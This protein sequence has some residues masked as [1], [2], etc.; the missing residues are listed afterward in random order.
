MKTTSTSKRLVS[1]LLAVIMVLSMMTVGMVTSFAAQTDIAQTGATTYYLKGTFNNWGTNNPFDDGVTTLTIGAGTYTFKI[2]GSGDDSGWYSNSG[3]INDTTGT[4]AWDFSNDSNTCKLVATGGTYTFKL[5]TT[6]TGKT[7]IVEHS[8]S[9]GGDTTA[10]VF[11]SGENIYLYPDS[12]IWGAAGAQFGAHFYRTADNETRDIMFQSCND[13]GYY[14]VTVPAGDWDKLSLVR[15]NPATNGVFDWSKKWNELSDLS[16]VQNKNCFVIKSWEGGQGY[17]EWGSHPCSGTGTVDPTEEPTVKPTD[18][19]S[20]DPTT[21]E[22]FYFFDNS[23][24]QFM[25]DYNASLYATFDNGKKLQMKQRVDTLTGNNL[26]SVAVPDNSTKVSVKRVSKLDGATWGTWNNIPLS[27]KTTGFYKAVNGDGS[28]ENDETKFSPSS[29]DDITNFWYGAWVDTKGE[30]KAHDAVRWWKDGSNQYHIFLPSHTPSTFRLYSSFKSITLN[31]KTATNGN[32]IELSNIAS[33]TKLSGDYVPMGKTSS[34]SLY[35]TFHK[36]S[37]VSTLFL[38][39]DD[40]FYTSTIIKPDDKDKNKVTNYKDNLET[41]GSIYLYSKKGALVNNGDGETKLKK[42][43]GRGNSSFEA[44]MKLYGKYAYNFNLEKNVSLIDGATKTKK[45]CLLANNV[46]HAMLRNT[47]AYSIAAEVGL[48]YSPKTRHVDVFNVGEYIGAYTIIEKVEYG[49]KSLMSGLNSLDDC[50]KKMY[51]KFDP[52]GDY[53]DA[54]KS[55]GTKNSP[56]TYS[57]VPSGKTYKY[58]YWTSKVDGFT[59]EHPENDDSFKTNYNFLLEHE[60]D[61]RYDSEASWFVSPYTGQKVVVKYP[62]FATQRE[63][64]WIMDMYDKLENAA[65]VTKTID[66]LNAVCDTESFAKMYLIQELALNLDSCATSYYIHNQ[67]DKLVAG[68]VWDFDWSFGSY[69]KKK[70]MYN[71][72][73]KANQSKSLADPN[74]MF[75]KY[76][77]ISNTTN[78]TGSSSD[79]LNLQAQLTK[80]TGFW[81]LCKSLWTNKFVPTLDEYI[82]NKNYKPDG[83][84]ADK[85]GTVLDTWL[86]TL[87]TSVEMD[88]V[89]W[90]NY[91]HDEK[92]DWGTKVTSDYNPGTHDFHT[93]TENSSGTATKCYANTVH[94]LNDWVAERWNHMSSSSGGKLYDATLL[95][96]YKLNSVTMNTTRIDNDVTVSVEFDATYKGTPVA[97]TYKEFDLYVNGS[98]YKEACAI[99]ETPIVAI[100]ETGDTTIHVVAYLTGDKDKYNMESS[101]ETFQYKVIGPQYKVENVKFDWVQS[102]DEKTVKVTPAA[103]VT[104]GDDEV[105]PDQINYTIYRNGEVYVT[106]T[107]ETPSVDVTLV[108]GRVNEIYIVVSP[109]DAPTVTGSSSTVKFSCKVPETLVS[110]TIKFKSSSS[111]RYIP[112]IKVNGATTATAMTIGEEIGWNASG[113]QSY[114]WF[115]AN[116][117]LALGKATNITFTNS[118]SMNATIAVTPAAEGD[119][120]YFG[121]DNL[122]NGSTAVDLTDKA[123]NIRNF[124]KSATNMLTNDVTATGIATTSLDGTIYKLGDTDVDNK[125]TV[126]DATKTQMA[127]VGKT[128][129]SETGEALADFNLDGRKSIMDVTLTQVYLTQ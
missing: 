104:F 44:S 70:P 109:V 52:V 82:T 53:E 114:N 32:Y 35:I 56:K 28:W 120:Y 33:G 2:Y 21:L 59:Y 93:T 5:T 41:K 107:F 63:M 77:V 103:N 37:D 76:K 89:R 98:L 90:D 34:T 26:W 7:L 85:T 60:L 95:D 124:V 96:P 30:G 58:K 51:K 115:T 27:D 80:T 125:L 55:E 86:K 121:V 64:M 74:Q 57:G 4:N 11:P 99:T 127:L 15:F 38:N 19:P 112:K 48:A 23:P 78:G 40:L 87:N 3:T 102:A 75:I 8:T 14:Y 66:D 10:T 45:W 97:N 22:T 39:T 25:D 13:E 92:A 108:E 61:E 54:I 122:N 119:V 91:S 105:K 42:I 116:V 72:E 101:S 113:T 68:P 20:G 100:N 62:E 43:K 6:A 16:P 50:H 129:L 67:G 128:E 84:T 94:Y 36:S 81:N 118:Y 1:L 29:D 117:Q 126:I 79:K 31:G 111:V 106:N 12:G 46:D 65:Y 110:V 47:F 123:Q 83:T 49:E 24:D 18:P 17:G 73:T 88:N 69:H 71:S 9:G